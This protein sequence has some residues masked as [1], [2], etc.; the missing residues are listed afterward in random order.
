[1]SAIV[2][3]RDGGALPTWLVP[4]G[5]FTGGTMLASFRFV[6]LVVRLDRTAQQARLETDRAQLLADLGGTSPT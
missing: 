3:G 6:T 5:S 4:L 2:A 1:M